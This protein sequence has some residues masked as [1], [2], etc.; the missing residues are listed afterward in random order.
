M[1]LPPQVQR[2]HIPDLGSTEPEVALVLALASGRNCSKENNRKSSE[3]MEERTLL[4]CLLKQPKCKSEQTSLS[5]LQKWIIAITIF[6]SFSVDCQCFLRGLSPVF[7]AM[8]PVASTHCKTS[9]LDIYQHLPLWILFC[10]TVLNLHHYYNQS[11]LHIFGFL[12]WCYLMPKEI[13]Q[14]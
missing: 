12:S 14:Y 7:R 2:K 5:Q 6:S 11:L 13:R 3:I 8:L 1:V 10:W 4:F 9:T